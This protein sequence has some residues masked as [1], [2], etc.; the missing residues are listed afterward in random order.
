MSVP[1]VD[2]DHRAV[3]GGRVSGSTIGQLGLDAAPVVG[4]RDLMLITVSVRLI[5]AL[6]IGAITGL[7]SRVNSPAAR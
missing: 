1:P 3:G 5:V 4:R 6:T 2:L 7:P